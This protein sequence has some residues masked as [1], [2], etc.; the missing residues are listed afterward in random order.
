MIDISVDRLN[1]PPIL[2][3]YQDDE[4]FPPLVVTDEINALI[5]TTA[6]QN[7]ASDYIATAEE[8]AKHPDCSLK[9]ATIHLA[10]MVTMTERVTKMVQTIYLAMAD[11]TTDR[12]N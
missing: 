11:P 4:V 8:L 7:F 10:N 3:G 1:D 9:A 5:V 2:P 12:S 6:L